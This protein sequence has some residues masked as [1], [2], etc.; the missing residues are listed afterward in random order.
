MTWPPRDVD[1]LHGASNISKQTALI[2][3]GQVVEGRG[4]TPNRHDILTGSRASR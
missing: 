3:K 1:P 2:E 4:D